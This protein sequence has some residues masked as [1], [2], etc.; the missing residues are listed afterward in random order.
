MKVLIEE[1]HAKGHEITVVRAS[2]SWY[3][4]EKSPLYTS[5]TLHSP[6]GFEKNK[7][8]LSRLMEI[9]LQGKHASLW[10]KIGNRIQI[11]RLLLDLCSQL[12]KK[13]SKIVIQMFE[14]E[15]L[16]QSFHEAKY[17]VV[18]TD[19]GIGVGA[20]LA[21]RLQ[22]PLVFNV[23]WTIQGEAHFLLAPSPLSYILY[24]AT[25]LTDKMNFS[26]RIKNVL[27]Q[28]GS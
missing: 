2:T 8:F 21:R 16:M 13:M 12:H 14:D 1:L 11:E 6:G 26:Q 3:I 4:S 19:P 28:P 7:V 24:T 25:G 20:M 27:L 5:V 23:R 22:V 10:S 18:L 9:Q 15:N 17:D